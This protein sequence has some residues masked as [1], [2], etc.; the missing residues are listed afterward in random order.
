MLVHDVRIVPHI[1]GDPGDSGADQ[2]ADR[3][4]Q[5]DQQNGDHNIDDGG[6][7]G[8]VAAVNKQTHRAAE[9]SDGIHHAVDVVIQNENQNRISIEHIAV[10]E[11]KPDK[12]RAQ[13]EQTYRA[14]A[15]DAKSV[16]AR[17]AQQTFTLLCGFFGNEIADTGGQCRYKLR[18]KDIDGTDGLHADAAAQNQNIHGMFPHIRR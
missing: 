12:G 3:S 6:G 9:G 7:Q 17:F 8:P 1:G 16:K 18:C 14:G 13:T 10:T 11:D 2:N 15:E 4:D 5:T